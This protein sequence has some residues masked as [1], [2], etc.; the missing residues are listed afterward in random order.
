LLRLLG[1]FNLLGFVASV[2]LL[3]FLICWGFF[4]LLGLLG[5]FNLLG[6]VGSVGVFYSVWFCL[7]VDFF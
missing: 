6:F 5:F 2:V 4:N 7:S 3:G 1:F